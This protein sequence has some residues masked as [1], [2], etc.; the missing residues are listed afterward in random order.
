VNGRGLHLLDVV[1]GGRW[2]A[3]EDEDG[4]TVWFEIH[5][6]ERDAPS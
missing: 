1:S 5:A 2:G 4:R 6:E 3:H